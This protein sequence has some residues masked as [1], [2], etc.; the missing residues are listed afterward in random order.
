MG[1]D[2]AKIAAKFESARARLD[3]R[4]R[5]VERRL[6][7]RGAKRQR[8][9]LGLEAIIDAALAIVDAEGTE[10][11]SMRRV[12][13]AF[14]TGPASL[15]AYVRDKD[16]L[17]QL[18]LDRIS[19]EMVIPE[20]DDWQELVRGWAWNARAVFQRH[21]DAARLSF[22][23][24]PRSERMYDG[25]ERLL[26][27]MTSAGVPDQVAAW[28][29]DI[30]SLYIAADS[31]E[32]WLYTQRFTDGSGRPTEEVGAE[33]FAGLMEGAVTALPTAIYPN[34]ARLA[35]AMVAGG[36]DERFGFGVDML[37]AGFAAQISSE[38]TS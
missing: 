2:E 22:G 18:V 4:Q 24:I 1:S 5:E 37:I 38:K 27:A 32:G 7:A 25:A 8:S 26:G 23:W 30:M 9:V 12:A 3:A 36:N 10:A 33:Y 13:A 29:L 17:L 16:E 35:G 20:G 6:A 31:F 21:Q 14:D 19:G 15:Y 28:A 11:V 34:L